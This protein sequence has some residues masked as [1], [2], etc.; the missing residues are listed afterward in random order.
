MQDK[1]N[2]KQRNCKHIW[3]HRIIQGQS[4]LQE[5]DGGFSFWLEHY[6]QKCKLTANPLHIE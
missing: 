6:C 3:K 5:R 2:K 4:I 1:T